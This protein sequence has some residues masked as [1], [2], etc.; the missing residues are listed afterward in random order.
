MTARRTNGRWTPGQSGNPGGRPAGLAEVR[1]LARRYTPAAIECLVK[2]MRE[3]DTSHARIAAAK[4]ILDRAV[5]KPTQLL[6]SDADE[7]SV[8]SNE[9]RREQM[10]AGVA[11]A[12]ARVVEDHPEMTDN[13]K[14]KL[15]SDA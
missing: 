5:G 3:G 2:E 8:I 4:A 6:A 15:R 14:T 10:R 12:F 9:E 11:K 7:Q 1:E 13:T